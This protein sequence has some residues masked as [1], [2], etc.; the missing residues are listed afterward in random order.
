ML[1]GSMI[2]AATWATLV[3]ALATSQAHAQSADDPT[4]VD[5]IVVTGDAFSETDGYLARQSST[6]SR[7]PVDV[8]TLPNTIRILPAELFEDTR[9]TL[10]QEVTKYVSGVQTLPS[11]GSG[12]GYVVRGF[13]ANYETLLNGVRT[14][15]N[16]GDLVNVERIE[17][18]KGPVG[19]LYG[20]SGAFAG[21][22]NVI[23]R[24]PLDTFAGRLTAFAGSDEFYRLEGDFGGPL[25]SN[26]D[27]TYRL[28][29]AAESAGS[30]RD[31]VDSEK[32]V[33]APS[34][35]ARI[36]DAV[37]LRIDSLWLD[38]RYTFE[39]GL[40]ADPVTFTLP[41]GRTLFAPNATQ[42]HERYGFVAP[43]LTVQASD[44]LTLRLA[45]NYAD[46]DID[47]GSSRLGAFLDPDGRTLNRQTTEG[48]QESRRYTIQ[49]D[50]IYRADTLFEETVFLFGYERNWSEYTYF[51]EGQTL[52]SIDILS[53]V[54]PPVPTGPRDFLF[55]GFSRYEGNAAYGQVFAQVTDRLAL[56]A[57]YRYDWYENTGAFNGPAST[58]EVDRGS[59][60]VGLSYR[61]APGTVL[62]G[63]WAENF[64][65]NLGTDIEGDVFEPDQV[66]Q[67]EAGLRQD[68]FD[69]R[70]VAT[71]A[72]FDI[73][74][75]NVII[76]DI[77]DFNAFIAAGRQ[78]SEG[79]EFDLT[80]R[81]AEGLDVIATYTYNRTRVAEEDDPN[82]G[83]QL[84]AAPEHSASAYVK[85]RW[86]EG[87]LAGFSA[88]VGATYAARIQATLPSTVFIPSSVR[89]DAGVAY[90]REGWRLGLNVNNLTDE[91]S[92]STNLFSLTPL[93]PR[94]V[95]LTLERRFGAF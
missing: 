50:A 92:Y 27:L 76:P 1:E 32:V 53:G 13:F 44:A 86:F 67:F 40:P 31:N 79:V 42:T 51:A 41:V 26:G 54:N 45:A 7:F 60:R 9:A 43:E 49:S 83:E 3:G 90:E 78:T 34:I 11:F 10:P 77:D 24:R 80:G 36:N 35:Q 57:G 75:S 48:P 37:T 64:V 71:I 5:D 33:V 65:P 61:L 16:P 58:I 56:L 84:P 20:A 21:A 72:L 25:I 63:N 91:R 46:Y 23:T 82:F 73:E 15:D 69:G 18:V 12:T 52:P 22:I 14:G 28:T 47:I 30:F 59:P 87:S 95:F 66:R 74:R 55:E 81:V 17:I 70:A 62:Y 88:T 19:S 39:E 2:R 29:G 4:T 68:L 89:W 94:Q 38:R 8:D 6:A 85:R 93:P